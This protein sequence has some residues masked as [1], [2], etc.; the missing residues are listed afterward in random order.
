MPRVGR[1]GL[2]EC[3]DGLFVVPGVVERVARPCPCPGGLGAPPE[4]RE[5]LGLARPRG[6]ELRAGG[7]GRVV[8][9]EGVCVVAGGEVFAR[10]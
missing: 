4:G 2:V 1:E 9:V 10:L 5:G 3:L 8:G 6:V 7:K